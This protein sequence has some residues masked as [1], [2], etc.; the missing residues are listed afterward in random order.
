MFILEGQATRPIEFNKQEKLDLIWGGWG[1]HLWRKRF[2]LAMA[3]R[4]VAV[5]AGMQ[6]SSNHAL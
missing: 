4:P 2:F 1:E 5:S 6:L 3:R